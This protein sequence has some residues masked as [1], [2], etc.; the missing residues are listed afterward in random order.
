MLSTEARTLIAADI[1]V[2]T[3]RPW[4]RGTPE[5]V[6]S[7]VGRI[8]ARARIES[9]EMAT[10]ARPVDETAGVTKVVE[11]RAVQ[12]GFPFYGQLTL[13]DGRTYSH[14]MLADNGALVRGRSC[15]RS[16]VLRSATHW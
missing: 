15:W 11:L 16:S 5:R 2:T 12:D 9:I 4:Q 6:A 10:M 8:P 14:A 7:R 3:D 13:Q 1:L